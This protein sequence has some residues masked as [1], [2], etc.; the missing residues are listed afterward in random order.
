MGK[1]V[2]LKRFTLSCVVGNLLASSTVAQTTE[3]TAPVLLS[4]TRTL[5]TFPLQ[6]IR[7]GRDRFNN[8][9]AL[10]NV[11]LVEI[12]KTNKTFRRNLSRHFAVPEDRLVAFIEDALVPSTL[13]KDTRVMN[14]GVTKA[15]KI[16]GKN[17][18]LK[19]GTRIWATRDG[20]P[21]LKWDCSNPLLPK[22][23]ILREKPRSSTVSLA[24]PLGV[25]PTVASLL[26]P[27]GLEAPVGLTLAAEIPL[28]PLVPR[29][30]PVTVVAEPPIPTL[31]RAGVPAVG[32]ANL[33]LLPVA[34]VL[35][36]VVR[37][38]TQPLSGGSSIPEPGTLALAALG[39]T[40]LF[41]ALRRRRP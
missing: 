6:R 35:G 24:G 30:P 23:P 3:E 39:A 22:A 12:V 14:Y 1:F 9:P 13:T 25:V 18:V 5:H 15:G 21:I 20:K 19:K 11:E 10:T 37:S 17:T 40:G 16:Y 34:G 8:S 28:E 27:A 26:D 36:L 2:N 4:T 41:V 32:R 7:P 38:H 29:N 31:P 33:P